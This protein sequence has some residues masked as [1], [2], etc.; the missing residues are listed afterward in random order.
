MLIKPAWLLHSKLCDCVIDEP[1]LGNSYRLDET[2]KQKY[3]I[4]NSKDLFS[5]NID[6]L[7]FDISA[8]AAFDLLA[9]E[10]KKYS[11]II[12]FNLMIIPKNGIEYCR[13]DFYKKVVIRSVEY[14]EIRI[15]EILTR[16]D[17]LIEKSN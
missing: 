9:H 8:D 10:I 3:L 16:Y 12:K 4:S 2:R 7:I 15:D 11:R 1:E 17:V 5:S 6:D 13:L 14:Y